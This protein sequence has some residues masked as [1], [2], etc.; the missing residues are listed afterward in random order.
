[1]IAC[2]LAI[3][4]FATYS[5]VGS[6]PPVSSGQA[7]FE[8]L[9]VIGRSV[10][11]LDALAAHIAIRHPHIDPIYLT[12]IY[13]AYRDECLLENVSLAVALGQMILETDYLLFTGSVGPTQYNFA[14]LGVTGG[15]V[16]G[17][18][19]YDVRDGVRAHVQHLKAYG[20][21]E[22]LSSPIID[23]RFPLVR[24][25]SAPTVLALTGR[26]ATDPDYGTK[27]LAHAHRLLSLTGSGSHR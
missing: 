15:G 6:G 7:R 16:R 19:F 1:V 20:D 9:P 26:W 14:G 22:D 11:S 5:Q 2:L 12:T 18:R 13:R 24:R 3:P 21:E 4:P 17:L 27:V 23:P 25:G 8:D 10:V